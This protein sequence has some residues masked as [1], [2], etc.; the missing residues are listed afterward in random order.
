MDNDYVNQNPEAQ[1]LY[2]EISQKR[3]SWE[4]QLFKLGEG[5]IFGTSDEVI[6]QR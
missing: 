3:S 4:Y 6:G 1:Q 2:Q 5:V